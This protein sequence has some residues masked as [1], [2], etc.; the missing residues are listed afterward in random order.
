MTYIMKITRDNTVFRVYK[1]LNASG[2]EIA[3][4]LGISRT[5]VWKAIEKLREWNYVIESRK[6]VGYTII[7]KPDISPFEVA[8]VAF[9][10]L[11]ELVEEVW[12]YTEVDSTNQRAR[13]YGKPNTLFFAEKQT[14]GRGRMGRKWFSE[15][16]GLYF[17][18]TLKPRLSIEDIPK[19]TLTTGLAV[20]K[21]IP[22][23]KVKW[24]NDVLI[25]GKKVCGILCELIGEVEQPI[26]VVGIGINVKNPIPKE[27]E[28]KATNLSLN[29]IDVFDYVTKNLYRY[30]S[31]LFIGKWKDIRR[32]YI[33]NCETIG[34]FVKV[35]TLS[36]VY[37]GLA[38]GIDDDG[39]LIINRER[40]YAGECFYI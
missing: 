20:A 9:K 12:Y 32:E 7:S 3:R 35:K 13:E 5:A 23:A 4:K 14:L 11:K 22:N 30:Y 17:S 34:K 38:K 28:D 6:G 29:L 40:V 19:L 1:S 31:K 8:D 25:N 26:V 18:L 37:E 39:A 10:N 2:E 21:S 27:L 36:K 16:G 33:E 15:R 24:P